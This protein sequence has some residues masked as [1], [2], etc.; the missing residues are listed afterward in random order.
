M[1]KFFFFLCFF[2]STAF[3]M[4]QSENET[5]AFDENRFFISASLGVQM[6]G[7]K[8]EDFVKSNYSPLVNVSAGKWFVPYMALAVGYKGYYFNYIMDNHKHYY[9]FYYGEAIF[10][11]NKLLQSQKERYIWSIELHAGAGYFYNH[12]YGQPNICATISLS[13]IFQ[14]NDR[15]KT[16]LAA[17]AIMG[18]DIYQGNKDIL[19]SLCFGVRYL[20]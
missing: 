10:N 20:L 8:S 17:P 19:P 7:I 14:I 16:S 12:D 1:K 11:I 13:S 15:L 18:W 6:S 5:I 2:S 9:N 4:A 3:V